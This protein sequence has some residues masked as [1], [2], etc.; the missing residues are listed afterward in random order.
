[1]NEPAEIKS[2]PLC[3]KPADQTVQPL[4]SWA[5]TPTGTKVPAPHYVAGPFTENRATRR[6]RARRIGTKYADP[7]TFAALEQIRASIQSKMDAKGSFR[8]A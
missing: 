6:T 1:M 5:H 3:N 2:E 8:G 4:E 7:A